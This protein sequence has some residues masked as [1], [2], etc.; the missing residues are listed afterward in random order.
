M[1]KK[2]LCY[3]YENNPKDF[4]G[5]NNWLEERS[6]F[7]RIKSLNFFRQFRKW[8]TLKMWNKT[9]LREKISLYSEFLKEKLFYLDD[10]LR[11]VILNVREN[12]CALE[13]Y[14]VVSFRSN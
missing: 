8:K 13:D 5:L 14:R 6:T 7:D 10:N 11:S 9:I 1:S 4:Q 2:G 12:I 3:Y